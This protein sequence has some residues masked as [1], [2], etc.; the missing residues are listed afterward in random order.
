[1]IHD[2]NELRSAFVK[3]EARFRYLRA[4]AII[5]VFTA[6]AGAVYCW[7]WFLLI[8]VALIL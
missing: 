8:P 4:I 6:L 7:I 1:M 5:M 2:D 3:V